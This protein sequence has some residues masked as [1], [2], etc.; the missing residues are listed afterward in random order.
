MNSLIQ[1]IP[2]F[3]SKYRAN[4][5]P[6]LEEILDFLNQKDGNVWTMPRGNFGVVFVNKRDKIAIK[7]FQNDA[8][9]RHW[10]SYSAKYYGKNPYVPFIKPIMNYRDQ[11]QFTRLEYLVPVSGKNKFIVSGAQRLAISWIFIGKYFPD[12]Y[13]FIRFL[14][15][16]SLIINKIGRYRDVN[17]KATL[18]DLF[19]M[20]EIDPNHPAAKQTIQNLPNR[21]FFR[22]LYEN[23]VF[24]NTL[25]D[26]Y[27][28]GRKYNMIVDLHSGNFMQ[29]ENGQLVITDP[30]NSKSAPMIMKTSTPIGTQDMQNMGFDL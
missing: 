7:L 29:R 8:G 18:A 19:S 27:E 21:D 22:M 26:I 10:A 15:E 14:N 24:R 3:P 12:F 16:L 20:I 5:F 2:T 23:K 25:N 11:Y 4:P 28:S 9:Y 6:N 13:N 30:F 1:E 17:M